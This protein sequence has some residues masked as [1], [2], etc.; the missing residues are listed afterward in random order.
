MEWFI[1]SD[2]RY[3]GWNNVAIEAGSID[4][5]G[6]H[7]SKSDKFK[8]IVKDFRNDIRYSWKMA[9]LR[10]NVSIKYHFSN[11]E[12]KKRKAR[13]RLDEEV[14]NQYRK[15]VS[16]TIGKWRD[17]DNRGEYDEKSP[18][19]MLWWQGYD[20][21]PEMV[22]RCVE[23]CQ[24][25]AG[26]HPV[27]LLG[28]DNIGNYLDVPERMIEIANKKRMTLSTLADYIRVALIS[29]Y[30]GLWIDVTTYVSRDIPEKY[31]QMP[32][33]SCKGVPDGGCLP[34]GR[35]TGYLLGGLKGNIVYTFVKEAYE[36][37]WRQAYSSIDYLALDHMIEISYREISACKKYIDELEPNNQRIFTLREAMMRGENAENFDN[38]IDSNTVFYKFSSHDRFGK[39][40]PDGRESLYA[41]FMSS[42]SV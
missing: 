18:I 28:K 42:K 11:D 1:L 14:L 5:S 38:F 3:D 39:R 2:D 23:L 19:W 27:I 32:F 16:Y 7:M 15:R 10:L 24:K 4:Y 13:Q 41:Y 36:E 12:T 34:D 40:T 6:D 20:N 31:F 30:G 37:Y 33:F 35:W 9:L 25:N 22:K 29:V 8:T 17:K 26:S 21:A